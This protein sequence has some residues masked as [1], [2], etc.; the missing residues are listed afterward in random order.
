MSVFMGLYFQC[1]SAKQQDTNR[2]ILGSAGPATVTIT[3]A[4]TS[5]LS[6][7]ISNTCITS[8]T[9]SAEKIPVGGTSVI[10][11]TGRQ[12]GCYCLGCQKLA[13]T[14]VNGVKQSFTCNIVGTCT[15]SSCMTQY[16]LKSCS[17]AE[18][19]RSGTKATLNITDAL[20]G[21]AMGGSM[22]VFSST[23]GCPSGVG[24]TKKCAELVKPCLT[25]YQCYRDNDSTDMGTC[26]AA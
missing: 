17:G 1:K 5:P 20:F 13:I 8:V 21:P 15:T 6:L 9:V 2:S 12:P 7:K 14:V 22:C 19:N 18:V 25:G 3:N 24:T 16:I 11:F 4:S 26:W 23:T 10:S